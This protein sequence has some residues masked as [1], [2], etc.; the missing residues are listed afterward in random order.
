MC[1]MRDQIS[2]TAYL[3]VH[4]RVRDLCAAVQSIS[5]ESVDSQV[6]LTADGQQ[7][8]PNDVIGSYSIGTVRL[9]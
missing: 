8:D 3:H 6:L 5:G 7:M 9:N 4:G 2:S 1:D